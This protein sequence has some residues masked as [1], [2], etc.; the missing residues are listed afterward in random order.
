MDIPDGLRWVFVALAALQFLVL[1]RVV[2]GLRVS[3]A[4]RSVDARLD[5]LDLLDLLDSSSSFLLLVGLGFDNLVVG[6]VGLALMGVTLSLKGIRF[7]R[8]RWSA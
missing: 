4:D 1:V 7:V 6:F 8:T 2:R 3:E 5:L